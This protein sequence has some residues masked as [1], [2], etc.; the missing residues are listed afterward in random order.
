MNAESVEIM[1]KFAILALG[2]LLLIFLIAVLT[3]K[4]AAVID[5]LM[6]KA[7]S[8]ERVEDDNNN[9]N[10]QPQVRGIYDAQLPDENKDNNGDE[11]NG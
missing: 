6:K 8:P 10:E 4:A 9:N 3:P 1:T 2:F 5:K 7:P 11:E